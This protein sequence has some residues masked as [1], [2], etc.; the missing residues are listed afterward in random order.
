[1]SDL[2]SQRFEPAH[3]GFPRL[4]ISGTG[5]AADYARRLLGDLG[6]RVGSTAGP[7]DLHP[8]LA[9]A[10]S[11]AMA[12]TGRPD[13][14]PR[15]P[16]GPLASCA[17][18]V[19]RALAVTGARPPS[20]SAALL[21]E[22]AALAGLERQGAISPGGACR[23]LRASDGW[24]ALNL[25]RPDDVR[26]LPAWLEAEPS[27]DDADAWSFAAREMRRLPLA[28]LA[29]RAHWIGLPFAAS[30]PPAADAPWLRATLCGPRAISARAP[31][32][33]DF[34]SLW[35]GPLCSQLLLAA[36]ARVIKVE[37]RARPDGA[38][39]GSPAFFDLLH[40]GK[41]SVQLDFGDER[42]GAWLE[43]LVE[44]ADIV[45]ESTR[46][47]A[48]AQLGLDAESFVA[49]RAGRV[50]VSITGYGRDDAAPGRV[51][52]GDDAAVAAGLARSVAD[53]EGPLF[54]GDAIADPLGGLHA[55]LAAWATWRTGGGAL[56]DL[57]LRDVAAHALGF[58]AVGAYEI[59][60]NAE[61]ATVSA[62]GARVAVAQT[63]ARPRRGA[64]SAIG[65]DNEV[66]RREFRIAC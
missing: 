14:T 31:R 53:A 12:L 26:A 27:R 15:I 45:I 59:S 9:W 6:F 40:A 24:A 29:R 23:L 57:S 65:A 32:V 42:D 5:P 19:G 10:R 35:A 58:A 8:A 33:I 61:A 11:G 44:S 1:V 20:D 36:G 52:F 7:P 56:L 39:A 4:E 21:G 50:W 41:Q 49:A 43:A 55:A 66:L 16:S 47:R 2:L 46:P 22:R 64:A 17:E 48:L 37:S 28:V 13:A 60:G 30:T 54:C 51:A 62:G 3:S 38:R 34:S 18:G 25:A 63:R